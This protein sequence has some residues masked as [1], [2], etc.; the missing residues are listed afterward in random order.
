MCWTHPH[1]KCVICPLAKV[2]G[3]FQAG[4]MVARGTHGDLQ[5]QQGPTAWSL[6]PW[7]DD[8]G[9][10]WLLGSNTHL[11]LGVSSEKPGTCCYLLTRSSADSAKQP[12]CPT[13]RFS[14]QSQRALHDTQGNS[15]ISKWRVSPEVEDEARLHVGEELFRNDSGCSL[16]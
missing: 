4:Y 7:G 12:V 8:T 13:H 1:S 14:S 15:K 9:K 6:S 2:T 5:K 11:G 10:R 3:C 16:E